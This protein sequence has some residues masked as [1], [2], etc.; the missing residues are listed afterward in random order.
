M[1]SKNNNNIYLQ[2]FRQNVITFSKKRKLH[3]R[4]KEKMDAKKTYN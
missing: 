2:L 3:V 4:R 1:S